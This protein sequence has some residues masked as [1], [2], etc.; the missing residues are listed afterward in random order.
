[1]EVLSRYFVAKLKKSTKNLIDT[2]VFNRPEASLN[3][4]VT[5]FQ[6][7]LSFDWAAYWTAGPVP[8]AVGKVT[9]KVQKFIIRNLID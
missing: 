7:F 9:L 2:D 6:I 4:Q 1:M 8:R 3:L 5:S